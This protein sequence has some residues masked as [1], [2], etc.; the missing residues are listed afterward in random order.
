MSSWFA[1]VRLAVVNRDILGY[2]RVYGD[3]WGCIRVD[4]KNRAW[5]DG[6][7]TLGSRVL[8]F[9]Q[10]TQLDAEIPHDPK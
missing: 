9:T 7:Y 3:I 10:V 6:T 1:R 8:L 2:I 4:T 5:P